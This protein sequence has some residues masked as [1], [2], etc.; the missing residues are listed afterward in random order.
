MSFKSRVHVTSALISNDVPEGKLGSYAV[1]YLIGSMP[2]VTKHALDKPFNKRTLADMTDSG[3]HIFVK[4]GTIRYRAT[5]R[6]DSY[7]QRLKEIQ[8][9]LGKLHS[10][11][12]NRTGL[13]T[14]TYLA[15]NQLTKAPSHHCFMVMLPLDNY[16]PDSY[17][18]YEIE[19]IVEA[20]VLR[21]Y[22]LEVNNSHANFTE[23]DRGRWGTS[24]LKFKV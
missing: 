9:E 21:E 7:S 16:H 6:Y 8:T 15:Y 19:E 2:A 14:V 17:N 24:S 11:G 18:S 13:G 5:S 23:R 3:I 20:T 4:A 1:F 12:G 22:G 10:S